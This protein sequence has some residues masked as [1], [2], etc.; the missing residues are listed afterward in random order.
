ML[1]KIHSCE[2]CFLRKECGEYAQMGASRSLLGCFESCAGCAGGSKC[3]FTCPSRPL[4]FFRRMSEVGMFSPLSSEEFPAVRTETFGRYVPLLQGG[5]R[6]HRPLSLDFAALNLAEVFHGDK[7]QG[8]PFGRRPLTAESLRAEWGLRPDAKIVLSGVAK[9]KHLE[10]IWANFRSVDLAAQLASLRVSGVTA[11]NFTFWKEK[12]RLHNLWNR[13]R[14]LRICEHF[15]AAGVP[16]IPH[17][18]STHAA[19]WD[20]W[21]GYLKEHKEITAVCM[22]FGTGNKKEAV[23]QWK[24]NALIELTE[25]LGRGL[26]P[27]IL[28]GINAAAIIGSYFLFYTAIDSTPTM[29]TIHRQRSLEDGKGITTWRTDVVPTGSCMAD[30]FEANLREHSEGV[31]RRLISGG[32]SRKTPERKLAEAQLVATSSSAS[33]SNEN[34]LPLIYP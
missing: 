11:P 7:V 19:D 20:F 9:D 1:Q 8:L 2:R 28:G 18:N 31:M 14:M 22:E 33:P 27:I 16:V 25:R 17:I 5:L 34:E 15:A 29:K 21:Y 10:R 32:P 13:R 4:Q 26:H 24:I 30:A 23:R 12:P 3:S 6:F